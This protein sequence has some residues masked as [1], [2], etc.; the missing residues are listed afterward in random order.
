MDFIYGLPIFDGFS[1]IVIVVDRFSKYETFISASKVYPFEQAARLFLKYMVKYWGVQNIIISDRDTKFAGR[2]CNELF[3]LMRGVKQPIRVHL[4]MLPVEAACTKCDCDR[5]GK[6]TKKWEDRKHG[7][8]N[9]KVNDAVLAKLSG[10]L[11][12][13]Y[14]KGLVLIYEGSFKVLKWV[15]I[16]AYRLEFPSTIQAHPMF[17]LSLLKLYHQDEEKLD[18]GKSHQEPIG[19]KASYNKEV[20]VIHAERSIHRVGQWPRHE[21]LVQWKGH[22]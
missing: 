8:V 20:E 14:H 19:V 9:F 15:G 18:R 13:P 3:K 10:I 2:F 7:D 6:R 12:N 11:H 5:A 4:R 21:Y 1:S 16:M 17:H 22:P